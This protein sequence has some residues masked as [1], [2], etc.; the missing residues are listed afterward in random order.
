ME[1][2]VFRGRVVLWM[3]YSPYFLSGILLLCL[4]VLLGAFRGRPFFFV[5]S[6]FYLRLTSFPLVHIFSLHIIPI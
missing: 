4:F 2:I 6:F 1:G 3:L 5:G